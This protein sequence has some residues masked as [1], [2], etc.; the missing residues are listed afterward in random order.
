MPLM[1]LVFP[2]PLAPQPWLGIM[3]FLY[4]VT[5]YGVLWA[6]WKRTND[7]RMKMFL[8][9]LAIFLPDYLLIMNAAVSG[10]IPEKGS[11]LV[12]RIIVGGV[13]LVYFVGGYFVF[14]YLYLAKVRPRPD[15]STPPS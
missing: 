1:P 13:Q 2:P 9:V 14:K 7:F 3:Q 12:A 15:L 6:I 10:L 11:T 5:C 4:L 8:L